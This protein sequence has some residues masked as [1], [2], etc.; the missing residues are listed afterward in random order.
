[1]RAEHVKTGN[2][3]ERL[4]DRRIL[5]ADNNH[6]KAGREVG[7]GGVVP[8]VGQRFAGNLEQ[9]GVVEVAGGEHQAIH[10]ERLFSQPGGEAAG[11]TTVLSHGADKLRVGPDQEP[12]SAGHSAIVLE[13]LLARGLGA[14]RDQR[15]A[16]DL[17]PLRRGEKH[18]PDRV[19]HDGVRDGAG[20]DDLRVLTAPPRG[21]GTGEADWAGPDDQNFFAH[22]TTASGG[23]DN[24]S[25]YGGRAGGLRPG[26]GPLV[27]PGW[28][29]APR[30]I[31]EFSATS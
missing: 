19:A 26:T 22:V 12:F 17:Q 11:E 4:L 14:G 30:L 1:M 13:G 21:D 7:L 29:A 9:V 24:Q 15:M 2:A 27:F 18:H 23:W 31:Q 8:N 28:S 20:V 5:S 25:S 6:A 3:G 10:G 16:A